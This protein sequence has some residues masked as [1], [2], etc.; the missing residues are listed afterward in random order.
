[1]PPSIED[2]TRAIATLAED[3]D[4]RSVLAAGASAHARA[5]SW[6]RCAAETYGLSRS[7]KRTVDNISDGL[8]TETQPRHA[9]IRAASQPGLMTT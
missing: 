1:V 9:K 2:I 3:T 7:A 4:T 8:L 6:E 5:L